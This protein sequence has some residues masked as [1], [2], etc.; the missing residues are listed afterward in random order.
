[1]GAEANDESR[2]EA[3]VVLR[4]SIFRVGGRVWE[5]GHQVFGLSETYGEMA[6]YLEVQSASSGHGKSA[7]AS[8]GRT[9]NRTTG[10]RHLACAHGSK[11]TLD[12]RSEAIMPEGYAR[13]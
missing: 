4:Y 11:Q 12:E 5:P 8:E 6:A 13:T 3:H 10:E 1:M 2:R 7:I 9:T